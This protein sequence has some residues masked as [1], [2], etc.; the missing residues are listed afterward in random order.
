MGMTA[1]SYRFRTHPMKKP[2]FFAMAATLLAVL[3]VAT[4]S[5]PGQTTFLW[6][7]RRPVRMPDNYG[8]LESGRN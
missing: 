2:T 1:P 3:A 6:A 5:S 7:R 4:R 8:E